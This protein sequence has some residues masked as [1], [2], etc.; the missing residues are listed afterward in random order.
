MVWFGKSAARNPQTSP[1]ALSRLAHSSNPDVVETVARNPSTPPSILSELAASTSERTLVAV[2]A[3]PSTPAQTLHG[4]TDHRSL[5]VKQALA[6]NSATPSDALDDL[7]KARGVSSQTWVAV[8]AN[9]GADPK[10][11][12]WLA[13]VRSPEKM[14]ILKALA[15][16]R[17]SS[18]WTRA[19]LLRVDSLRE[20]VFQTEPSEPVDVRIGLTELSYLQE[21]A[22][23]TVLA[24]DKDDRVR[25]A[26]A[27]SRH[28]DETLLE[29]LAG[30]EVDGVSSVARARLVTDSSELARL[31]S[32]DDRMVLAA[33]ALNANTPD[34]VKPQIARRLVPEAGEGTLR[35]LAQD[36]ATPEDVLLQLAAHPSASI[37]GAVSANKAVTAEI[38]RL[39]ASDADAGIRARAG[40]YAQLPLESLV[41]LAT[42][43]ETAVRAAVAGNPSTPPE[44][45]RRLASDAEVTVV[46]G[47]AKNPSATSG[48]LQTIVDHHGEK[49]HELDSVAR[50]VLG[51]DLLAEVAANPQ[52][53]PAALQVLAD[54]RNA[55]RAAVA[56]NPSTP[57]SVLDELARTIHEHV[58]LKGSPDMKRLDAEH[59]RDRILSAIVRNPSSSLGTL[60][61]LSSGDW[62]ARKTTTRSEREDGHTTTWTIWDPKATEA[63]QK[64]KSSWVLG[65]ISKRQWGVGM[66]LRSRLEFA[67]NDHTTPDIL[68]ELAQD[69]DDAVRE[70]VA[71]NPSTHRGAFLALARDSAHGVRL[72]A[73]GASHPPAASDRFYLLERHYQEAFELLATDDQAD[74]RAAVVEN[75]QVFWQVIS[76]EARERLVFDPEPE[77]QGSLAK[78]YLARD[79]VGLLRET[80]SASAYDQLIELGD[81]E[82]WRAIA[83]DFHAPPQVLERLVDLGDE[84]ATA[85]ALR[86]IDAESEALARLAN[87]TI[88]TVVEA[89][90]LRRDLMNAPALTTVLAANVVTPPNELERL[91]RQSKDDQTL[92]AAIRNPTFPE[93][94]LLQFASGSDERFL[95][96]IQGCGKSVPIR[97]LAENPLAPAD[98]LASLVSVDDPEVREALLV[99]KS[100]P[101]DVLLRLIQHGDTSKP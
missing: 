48:V 51:G 1:S 3:N 74:V 50:I 95:R 37:R 91:A 75:S 27:I 68:D 87:S 77:V 99:N 97:K 66:D 23:L 19:S 57:S 7:A 96:A 17:A 98:V 32:T 18:T 33:L 100:T 31:A 63:A 93:A 8:A 73:A 49:R 80:L 43:T 89:I 12:K 58:W 56:G 52:T 29:F 13:D 65:E 6:G 62:A 21:K 30:D 38:L 90:L 69:S 16:N 94:T 42:A 45:L 70:A 60:Q 25:R 92:T 78:S 59:E 71:A 34:E 4:L 20:L 79:K 46:M 81:V 72:A 54:S 5:A 40:G 28:V 83:Y 88:P 86:R 82:V 47:V 84:E 39:L 76:Q 24:H 9:S 35:V 55:V 101:A 67:S 41:M 36:Q 15:G 53:P 10:T 85:A 22:V 26:V 11:L 64:D 2:A 61:F 14:E 44:I